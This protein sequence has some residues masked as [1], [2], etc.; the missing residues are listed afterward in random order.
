VTPKLTDEM[1]LITKVR[2]LR[3]DCNAFDG[4]TTPEQRCDIV[5]KAIEPV[6]DVTFTIRNGKRITMAMQFADVYG[7]VP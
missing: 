1:T 5:R 6:L 2:S 7:V 3:I 4:M